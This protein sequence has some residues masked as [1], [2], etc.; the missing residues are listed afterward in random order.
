VRVYLGEL[1]NNRPYMN[2]NLRNFPLYLDQIV[3]LELSADDITS[4]LASTLAVIH[5]KAEIDARDVEFVLGTAP[6]FSHN[7]A[8]TSAE[9]LTGSPRMSSAPA[10]TGINFT[11]RW[12]HLWVLDFNECAPITMDETGMETAAVAFHQ[13]APYCPR[14]PRAATVSNAEMDEVWVTFEQSYLRTSSTVLRE[15]AMDPQ[16]LPRLF[17]EKVKELRP[18]Q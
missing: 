16:R 6:S 2:F 18:K 13:N 17:I 7:Q 11:N 14:P 10:G 12:I 4:T 3:G 5:F 8:P 9:I 1:R 15:R